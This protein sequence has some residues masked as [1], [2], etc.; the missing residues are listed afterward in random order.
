MGARL[1]AA[2]PATGCLVGDVYLPV[3]RGGGSVGVFAVESFNDVGDLAGYLST[4]GSWLAERGLGSWQG[5]GARVDEGVELV[6][7]VVGEGAHVTGEGR[8]ERCVVWPGARA[9]A[10][11]EDAVIAPEGIARQA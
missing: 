10:P 4:N 6:G 1:R 5:H 9:V 7:S 2:L 11:L 3:L 8:L